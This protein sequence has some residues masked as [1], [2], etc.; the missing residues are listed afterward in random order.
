MA[1][2]R[3]GASGFFVLPVLA[4]VETPAA[5]GGNTPGL[6][7]PFFC[8]VATVR[9]EVRTPPAEAGGL[10]REA[11][12]EAGSLAAILRARTLAAFG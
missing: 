3:S 4:L 2:T 7:P 6:K 12:G 9:T 10:I 11:A 8:D 1:A 5:D